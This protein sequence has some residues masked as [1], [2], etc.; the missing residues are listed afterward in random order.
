M[1]PIRIEHFFFQ[2]YRF[3]S[4]LLRRSKTKAK[5]T[6]AHT[7]KDV[8]MRI[9]IHTG[10]VLTG[11]LGLRKFQFDIFSTDTVIANNMESSGKAGRCHI[12]QV[13]FHGM[14]TLNS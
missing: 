3:F 12:S 10:A 13:K 4:L 1:D 6:R 8:D 9:G 2:K 11:V 5:E 14:D 7:G